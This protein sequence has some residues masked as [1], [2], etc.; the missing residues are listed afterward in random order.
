[1]ESAARDQPGDVPRSPGRDRARSRSLVVARTPERDH[2]QRQGH[3][4]RSPAPGARRRRRDRRRPRAQGADRRDAERIQQRRRSALD[5]RG[6]GA[7][8]RSADPEPPRVLDAGQRGGGGAT[9]RGRG[10]RRREGV[11]PQHGAE[12]GRSRMARRSPGERLHRRSRARR[13]RLGGPGPGLERIGAHG[14]A[15]PG[16]EASGRDHLRRA[17]LHAPHGHRRIR[18]RPALEL[19]RAAAAE[20]LGDRQHRRDRRRRSRHRGDPAGRPPE[21]AVREHAM[22][23]AEPR[24]AVS[25]AQPLGG[26]HRR[27]SKQSLFRARRGAPTAG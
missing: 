12:P 24:R 7:R 2:A 14:S 19:R 3:R 18:R 9:P 15:P 23:G 5:A 4:L 17:D 20:F 26:R 16:N 22:A 1:M 6:D 25:T 8:D 13:R 11:H 10:R 21:L 27:R